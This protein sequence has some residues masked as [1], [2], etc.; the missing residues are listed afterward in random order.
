L[1][2]KNGAINPIYSAWLKTK[3]AKLRYEFIKMLYAN[4]DGMLEEAIKDLK[5]K[6]NEK[7]NPFRGSILIRLYRKLFTFR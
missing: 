4:Y 2:D 6:K 7:N 3:D 1:E 5:R